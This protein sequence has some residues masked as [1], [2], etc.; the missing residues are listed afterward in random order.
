MLVESK[1]KAEI[2]SV[3]IL[4]E[5]K[6]LSDP[7]GAQTQSIRSAVIYLRSGHEITLSIAPRSGPLSPQRTPNHTVGAISF[8]LSP[9]FFLCVSS[10]FRKAP[11]RPSERS[12][13][14]SPPFKRSTRFP[15]HKKTQQNATFRAAASLHPAHTPSPDAP[16]LR[17]TSTPH[18]RR[19]ESSPSRRFSLGVSLSPAE[20]SN[21]HHGFQRRKKEARSGR[22]KHRV[23]PPKQQIA[24]RTALANSN[25]EFV[26]K[27]T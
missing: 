27:C 16:E 8:F 23:P 3:P 17:N 11:S 15:T 13:S 1:T 19:K 14:S 10:T 25:L 9:P 6:G 18:I 12:S 24:P 26:Q 22:I 4:Q 2:L 21:F 20:L 7:P 5:R